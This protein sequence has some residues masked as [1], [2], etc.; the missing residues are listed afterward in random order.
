MPMLLLLLGI[1]LLTPPLAQPAVMRD[2]TDY[3]LIA[4]AMGGI[5]GHALTNTY[6][7]FAANYDKGLRLFEADLQFTADGRLAAFHD[8]GNF[9]KLVGPSDLPAEGAASPLPLDMF[10]SLRLCDRYRPL[11]FPD[12]VKL[13]GAYHDVYLVTDTKSRSL[14]VVERQFAQIAEALRIEGRRDVGRR[15]VPQVY[16]PEMYALLEKKFSFSSYIYTLY[17]SDLSD[18]EVLR[19][20][21]DAPKIKAVAMPESRVSLPFVSALKQLGRVV[22]THTV[23]DRSTFEK[24]RRLGVDGVYTDFLY[25]AALVGRS[26]SGRH[27]VEA[28]GLA[29]P[30]ALKCATTVNRS[31]DG[32]P[33]EECR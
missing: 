13:L 33:V 27:P 31:P 9:R 5:D 26:A 3:R 19:F 32:Q 4:H 1:S 23:N 11:D 16:T 20:L 18:G 2:W 14:P 21:R 8:W 12:I 6:E 10:K 17:G 25:P 22:Y 28:A 24:Y 30:P 7:A 15:I 29:L